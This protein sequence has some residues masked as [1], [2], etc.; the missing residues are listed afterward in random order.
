M[1]QNN[2]NF[3]LAAKHTARFINNDDG[4]AFLTPT[5]SLTC[6]K[7]TQ[8]VFLPLT[9]LMPPPRCITWLAV[10]EGPLGVRSFIEAEDALCIWFSPCENRISHGGNLIYLIWKR[11]SSC[12]LKFPIRR[13]FCIQKP[14]KIATLPDVITTH[15]YLLD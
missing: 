10:N 7:Q 8:S 9:T 14:M 4:H 11:A 15:R 5:V 2:L 12:W 6:C 1:T 3:T 13:L